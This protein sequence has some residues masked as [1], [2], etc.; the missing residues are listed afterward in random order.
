MRIQRVNANDITLPYNNAWY[1]IL[2]TSLV[3]V[4]AARDRYGL[5]PSVALFIPLEM[6]TPYC[7]EISPGVF[8]DEVVY[9][10]PPAMTEDIELEMR[11]RLMKQRI[12]G[13]NDTIFDDLR[14]QFDL[15]AGDYADLL[16]ESLMP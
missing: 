5:I 14:A 7:P 13:M 16:T 2:F 15:H 8:S 1:C 9:P 10:D 3:N 12:Q 4:Q 6:L 11:V